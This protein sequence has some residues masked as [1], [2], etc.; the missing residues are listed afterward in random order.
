MTKMN[1]TVHRAVAMGLGLVLLAGCG[2]SK[3]ATAIPDG[4]DAAAYVTAKFADQLAALNKDVAGNDSRKAKTD[5]FARIDDKKSDS[6][7]SA[8]QIGRPPARFVKNHSNRNS[9]EF[10][11]I[12]HPAGSPVEYL[13]LGPVYS[14][15][16]PT[17]WVSTPYTSGQRN[18]CFW[19]GYRDVCRMLSAVATSFEQGAAGKQARSL[20]DGS[21]ELTAEVALDMFFKEEIISFPEDL[22]TRVSE[23]MRK[24]PVAAKVVLDNA[25]KLKQIEMN[26][27]IKGDGH[28]VEIRMKYQVLDPPTENDLPK[29]P[30][31]AEVTNLPDATAVRDF[32]DRMGVIQGG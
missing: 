26:G 21:V 23:E 11:D 15:L 20:P 10:L 12:Y 18:A 14:S 7:L 16:A 13:L 28:E 19:E 31:P 29:I 2:Q 6:T 9:N 32:Y 22:L 1:R 25:G 4:D 27:L 8:V 3:V 5:R 30:D 17:Q 24:E